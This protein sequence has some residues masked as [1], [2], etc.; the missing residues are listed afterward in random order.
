MAQ[1]PTTL[2]VGD[3]APGFNDLVAVVG[4][5]TKKVSRKDL[6][7]KYVVL[8]FYPKDDTP[9][10]TVEGHEYSK[11]LPEFEKLNCVVYGASNDS[12]EAHIK[13]S[14]GQSYS[15]PLLTDPSK[16]LVKD[17]YATK[18]GLGM[19]TTFLISPEGKILQIWPLGGESNMKQHVGKVV[20][21]VKAAQ[22]KS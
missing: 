4:E 18:E 13:F 17:Y 6:K 1:A 10:C 8:Y 16:K 20:E 5:D 9:T 21:A 3:P 15:V 14:C 11:A 22:K 7:G 19:R 12:A 2:K